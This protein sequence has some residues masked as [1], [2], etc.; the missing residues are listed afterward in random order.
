MLVSVQRDSIC[1]NKK[2]K[3]Y[4]ETLSVLKKK[5]IQRDSIC[6]IVAEYTSG[7]NAQSRTLNGQFSSVHTQS[8][9][10][11]YHVLYYYFT[12]LRTQRT[13]EKKKST[14]K[15]EK[16]RPRERGTK[17]DRSNRRKEPRNIEKKSLE[18]QREKEKKLPGTQISKRQEVFE[19]GL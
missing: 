11:H 17:S 16:K 3:A 13:T 7:S 5:R 6:A 15:R 2:K 12:G 18:K 1:A 4:R 14:K 10:L 19:K 9:Y 8:L